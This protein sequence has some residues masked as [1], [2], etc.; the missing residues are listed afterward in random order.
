MKKILPALLLISLSTFP[1]KAQLSEKYSGWA[2]GPVSFLM[3]T[4]EIS[5][6][7]ALG[8]DRD[9]EN[10]I[11]LFWARRDPD[12]RTKANE[13]RQQFEARVEAA[14]KEF[15]E[16]DLRGAMSDRGKTLILLGVPKEH[17]RA[18]IGEYLSRIYRT[19]RPPRAS[20]A[21]PD[22]H[23]QMQGISFNLNKNLADLWGYSREEIPESI[24]WPTHE[25]LITFAFFDT[26]GTGHF[27]LQL[28]IRKSAE[29]IEILRQMPEKILLHPELTEIPSFGLVPGLAAA[30]PAELALL[31]AGSK[32]DGAEIFAFKGVGGPALPLH[33]IFYR[34]PADAPRA[35]TMIGR[36]RTENEDASSFRQK[37]QATGSAHGSGYELAIPASG[38]G[39]LELGLLSGGKLL[40][41]RTIDLEKLEN[42]KA[43]MTSVFSGAEVEKSPDATAGDPFIFG[44]YHLL[45][46]P[47][48][49]FSTSDN[50]A[51]FAL[52]SLPEGAPEARPGTVR[53]RWVIDGKPTRSQPSQ[54]VLFAPAGPGVWVWGTQLPLASLTA[55]HEYLLRLSLKDT[56]SD[57]SMKSEI[58]LHFGQ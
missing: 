17:A 32:I 6:F 21:D 57:I 30:S 20:S 9:A 28:G 13:F 10:F 58:P 29:S 12:P 49:I 22:A 46:R 48:G 38:N 36:F 37:I 8:E 33:W 27:K 19:G 35:D 15:A 43:F 4:E 23:I 55:D 53:M 47:A 3:T 25:E 42:G 2:D 7:Q 26:E 56:A 54:A 5:E 52:L 45:L 39:V 24:K 44:G 16:E 11:K 34:L 1:L 51:L 18:D 41:Y 14:D 50:L 40:D 31:D